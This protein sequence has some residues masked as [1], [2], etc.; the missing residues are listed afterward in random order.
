MFEELQ[1]SDKGLSSDEAKNRLTEYGPNMIDEK[2]ENPIFKFLRYFW[3]PISWMIEI[4]AILSAV[5]GH[6]VDLIIILVMLVFN[7]VVGFWQEYQ[8]A[9]VLNA[10]KKQL[11]LT[12][13]VLRDGK[14][15]EIPAAELVPGDIIR[16]RAG[17]IIPADVKLFDGDYLSIDESSLTGES[18]RG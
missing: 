10:L 18:L 14:W 4:A 15:K 2:K 8:A 3:G 17:D 12:A 6:W 9:N 1:S 16:L 5:V 7:A 13:R 11:A